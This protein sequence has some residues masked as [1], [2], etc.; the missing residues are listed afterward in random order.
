MNI[1][2]GEV[3]NL[4]TN[5]QGHFGMVNNIENIQIIIQLCDMCMFNHLTASR[6]NRLAGS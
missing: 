5:V 6:T 2:M 4:H 1:K 3:V